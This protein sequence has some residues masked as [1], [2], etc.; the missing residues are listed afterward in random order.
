MVLS[1]CMCEE[2][3]FFLSS[4]IHY[5]N[6]RPP[7]R[8][9]HIDL[10]NYFSPPASGSVRVCLCIVNA[11]VADIRPQKHQSEIYLMI[12]TYFGINLLM[13]ADVSDG[14]PHKSRPMNGSIIMGQCISVACNVR[15][16]NIALELS[17]DGGSSLGELFISHRW[18]STLYSDYNMHVAHGVY[19]VRVFDRQQLLDELW[20]WTR[21][22]YR[23]IT[24]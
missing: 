3:L 4:Y 5:L 24:R 13:M 12:K 22:G 15:I 7:W 19:Y 21:T 23:W 6:F 11:K 2:G 9:C 18:E 20:T 10:T 8:T 1:V 16:R 17:L 14:T